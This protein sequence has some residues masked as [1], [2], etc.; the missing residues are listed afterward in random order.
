MT[1]EVKV[2]EVAAQPILSIRARVPEGELV[3]F[4]DEACG[5]MYAYLE[6]VG[7]RPA[8][9]PMSQWY[10]DPEMTPGEAEIETCIPVEQ[11]APSSGRV[12][13]GALPAGPLAYTV[14]DGPYD[15]MGE[16]FD[17][18]RAWIQINGRKTAGPPRDVVLVGPND[19]DNALAYR[20]E[21]AWPI[22]EAGAG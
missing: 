7:V 4:F 15:N 11:H 20:T 9:P 5:E 14:H 18:V 17:A 21:I 12:K 8:G 2:K 1:Y 22:G 13:A 6:R 16:A 3:A 19:T 10:S